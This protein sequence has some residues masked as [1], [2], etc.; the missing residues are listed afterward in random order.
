MQSLGDALREAGFGR[1]LEKLAPGAL[2]AGAPTEE[3]PAVCERCRGAG[4]LRRDVLPGHPDFG[5]L[6]ECSCELGQQRSKRRQ[7][8]IWSE[9][10]VPPKMA[11]YSFETL[12]GRNP[13]LAD[14]LRAWLATDAWLVMWGPKG[15][16]KTGA[17]VACLLE[18]VRGGGTGLYVVLPTFLARIRKTYG[19]RGDGPDEMEVLQTLIDTEL[20]V[21]DDIGTAQ[22]TSWGQEKL[23]W[24]IN[25][26]DLHHRAEAP[27][28]TIVTTNLPL[29]KLAAH[30]DPEGR[31]WDRIRGWAKVIETS[32]VSQRGLDL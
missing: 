28:R 25:E 12:A 18:H 11:S 19:D 6:I 13:A 24:V 10:L 9:A 3:E 26:R 29:A 17:A 30:L 20:L 2:E 7:D 8:R 5:K 31:T 14:E 23:F 16:C 22:L 4:Y 21:L 32:G 15:T 27:R 1:V